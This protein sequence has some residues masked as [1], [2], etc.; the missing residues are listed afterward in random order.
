MRNL[1][2]AN[3]SQFADCPRIALFQPLG[4]SRLLHFSPASPMMSTIRRC[5]THPGSPFDESSR[6]AAPRRTMP[7]PG[8]LDGEAVPTTHATTYPC[9]GHSQLSYKV[10]GGSHLIQYPASGYSSDCHLGLAYERNLP[11]H[12]RRRIKGGRRGLR[13]SSTC[14]F[15]MTGESHVHRVI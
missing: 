12:R 13:G 7:R 3:F 8:L 6:D 4:A 15:S 2:D 1:G 10:V 11:C 9:S 14:N 5:S